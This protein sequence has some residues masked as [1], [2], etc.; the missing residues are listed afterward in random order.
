MGYPPYFILM[1]GIIKMAGVA[2]LWQSRIKWLR[3]WAFAGFAFDTIFAFVSGLAISSTADC[4]KSAFAFVVILIAFFK[5]RNGG[6]IQ[7]P[8]RAAG[9]AD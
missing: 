7:R 1:L 5:S 6:L 3:E 4:I 9:L 8:P 2:A